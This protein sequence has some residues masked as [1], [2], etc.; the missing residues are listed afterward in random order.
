MP[1]VESSSDKTKTGAARLHK[2]KV[3]TWL[4]VNGVL[5]EIPRKL[6]V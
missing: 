1:W 4:A 6:W 3:S 5:G 2:S